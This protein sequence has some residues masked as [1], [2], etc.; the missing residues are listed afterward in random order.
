MQNMDLSIKTIT[1]DVVAKMKHD[2][3]LFEKFV[4]KNEAFIHN[5]VRKFQ[6]ND[7]YDYDDYF[8]IGLLSL[9][10]SFNKFNPTRSTLSTFAYTCIFNDILQAVNKNNKITNHEISIENFM[11][12]FD[13]SNL[14]EYNEA[15]F[16]YPNK[17]YDFGNDIIND[18]EIKNFMNELDDLHKKIF[19]LR[20][21]KKMKHESV[22]D[23]VGLNIHTY[24]HIWHYNISP[25][26]KK[27][28]KYLAN[29]IKNR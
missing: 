3:K 13:N 10:N 4:R 21:L 28:K 6:P 11:R 25:K 9:F 27:L 23:K 17:N 26:I 16:N 2:E 22:A 29:D 5:I 1:N 15:F 12:S 8:Q 24:K 20:V 19:E 18:M 7:L 14:T